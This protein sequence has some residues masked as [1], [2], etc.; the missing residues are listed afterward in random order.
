MRFQLVTPPLFAISAYTVYL[1]QAEA[2]PPHQMETPQGWERVYLSR[3]RSS[4]RAARVSE[5]DSLCFKN[6]NTFHKK[7][8]NE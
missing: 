1:W 6:I 7:F 4:Q 2:T 3:L 5:D 8:K